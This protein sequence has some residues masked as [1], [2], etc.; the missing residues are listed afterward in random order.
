[1]TIAVVAHAEER[2]DASCPAASRSSRTRCP[3]TGA[4]SIEPGALLLRVARRP[5]EEAGT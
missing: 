1:M 5:H 3:T 2:M 4:S